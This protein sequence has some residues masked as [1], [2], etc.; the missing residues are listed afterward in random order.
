MLL[1][2]AALPLSTRTLTARLIRAHRAAAARRSAPSEALGPGLRRPRRHPHPHRWVSGGLRGSTHG[3]EAARVWRLPRP[4]TEH[5]LFAPAEEGYQGLD[6]DRVVTPLK[7]KGKPEWHKEADRLA[8]SLPSTI[9]NGNQDE[10]GSLIRS[11]K[12]PKQFTHATV[13]N[14]ARLTV[15]AADRSVKHSRLSAPT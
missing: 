9:K 11:P 13:A 6:F 2:Q 7:G 14:T 8:P 1:Y 15:G 5:G 12:T 4:L 10:K 3:T